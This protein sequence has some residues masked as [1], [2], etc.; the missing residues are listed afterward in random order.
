MKCVLVVYSH[1]AKN[2]LN[3]YLGVMHF[4]LQPH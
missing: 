3:K 4:N 1:L 2:V